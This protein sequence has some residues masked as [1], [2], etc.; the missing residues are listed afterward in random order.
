MLILIVF[1]QLLGFFTS[2]E[3]FWRSIFKCIYYC[4]Q[5]KFCIKKLKRYKQ[6]CL[7]NGYNKVMA[8]VKQLCSNFFH[9]KHV[10]FCHDLLYSEGLNF[11]LTEIVIKV[12][13]FK[14]KSKYCKQLRRA[15][16]LHLFY[17]QSFC[18]FYLL[19]IIP[20]IID[21]FVPKLHLLKK[22]PEESEILFFFKSLLNRFKYQIKM[23]RGFCIANGMESL[24]M[25]TLKKIVRNLD[26]A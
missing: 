22:K 19:L 23:Q 14:L 26:N 11:K 21:M 13:F 17:V 1:H 10:Y 6:F 7:F 9:A 16:E 5:L 24:R 4:L 8:D 20:I 3:K 18:F 25:P 12:V 2:R 15:Q